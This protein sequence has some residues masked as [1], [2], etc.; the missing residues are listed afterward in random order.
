[1]DLAKA[2]PWTLRQKFSLVIEKIARELTGT[3]CLELADADPVKQEICSSRM[4]GKSL[5]TIEPIKEA[6]AT[7]VH[8]LRKIES[9][10]FVVQEG[11]RQHPKRY[12]QS[13]GGQ[14]RQRGAG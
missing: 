6:V 3:S 9:A 8:R 13:G 10:E 14:V 1:M 11:P 7:Y 4:F 5:T 2:N 12:V